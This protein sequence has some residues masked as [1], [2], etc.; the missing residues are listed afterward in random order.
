MIRQKKPK[1]SEYPDR[2]LVVLVREY[3]ENL[4]VR[5]EGMPETLIAVRA[6]IVE[7]YRE[8]VG[9]DRWRYGNFLAEQKEALR[10]LEKEGY[11]ETVGSE[12]RVVRLIKPTYKGIERANY[13]M[14]PWYR[15][16]CDF[17]KGDIRIVVITIVTAIIITLLTT[18][19]LR[20]LNWS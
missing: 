12:Y 15:K 19:I 2:M 20:L 5:D 4:S 6:G 1:P 13:L 11:V 10:I 17:I 3:N 18:L 8:Q 7:D 9:D 16:V 14:R